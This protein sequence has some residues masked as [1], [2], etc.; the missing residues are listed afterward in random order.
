MG[1]NLSLGQCSLKGHILLLK[2]LALIQN[3]KIEMASARG[4]EAA[5]VSHEK[6]VTEILVTINQFN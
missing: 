1:R 5:D 3:C 2:L 6:K 4:T